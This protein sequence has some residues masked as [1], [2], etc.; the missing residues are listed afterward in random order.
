[1]HHGVGLAASPACLDGVLPEGYSAVGV[2]G[3]EEE[4]EE[5]ERQEEGVPGDGWSEIS[6]P[7]VC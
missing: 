1:M 4:E 7:R 6:R 2:W 3:G 5:E